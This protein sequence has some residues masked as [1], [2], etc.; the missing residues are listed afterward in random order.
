MAPRRSRV[1][2]Y[3]GGYSREE[4]RPGMCSCC[5]TKPIKR[6]NRFL[7][8]YCFTDQYTFLLERD[9]VTEEDAEYLE[10]KVAEIE[11]TP[12]TPVK[13]FSC[14]SHSQ[15]ELQAILSGEPT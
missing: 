13:H 15:E 6:G 14:D 7:C 5:L 3:P 1:R 11:R 8:S 2:I 4:R 9:I 10:K 12:P